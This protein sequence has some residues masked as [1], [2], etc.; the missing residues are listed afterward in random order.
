MNSTIFWCKIEGC[1]NAAATTVNGVCLCVR[2]C[3]NFVSAGV[4]AVY[5]AGRWHGVTGAAYS[6]ELDLTYPGVR[7]RE[8]EIVEDR[9]GGLWARQARA[10]R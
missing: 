3:Q 2:C 9:R 4:G 5:F 6:D 8:C 10:G 1:C 7:V